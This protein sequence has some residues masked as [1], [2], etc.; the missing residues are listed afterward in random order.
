MQPSI[1]EFRMGGTG[2][3]GLALS[4]DTQGFPAPW[5][6]IMF[7]ANPITRQVQAIKIYRERGGY[8]LEL[9]P[10]FMTTSDEW[11]RPVSIHFGPDACLYVVDWYNKIISHNEVPRNH[12]D[13]DKTRGRVWRIRP[14]GLPIRTIPN[15]AK[16][17]NSDLLKHLVS[18]NKW[19][20][21][22]ALHQIAQRSARE[23]AGKLAAIA[24]SGHSTVPTQAEPE[25]L[26]IRALWAL[27]SVRGVEKSLLSQLIQNL[28]PFVRREAVRVSGTQLPR[29]EAVALVA[30][31][32]EDQNH[33]VRSE[34]IRVA[35]GQDAPWKHLIISGAE[36]R[37]DP[38]LSGRALE[39][40]VAMAKPPLPNPTKA[41]PGYDRE[42]ER[43][44]IRA[45]LE[46]HPEEL[47]RFLDSPAAEKLPG[48]NMQFAS[49]AL[50]PS[51]AA[52]RLAKAFHQTPRIPSDEELAILLQNPA[53]PGVSDA[54]VDL[55]GREAFANAIAKASTRI[56]TRLN[57]DQVEPLLRPAAAILL[58]AK[59]GEDLAE[60][61]KLASGYKMCAL[62]PQVT[63]IITDSNT[64]LDTALLALRV[65]RNCQAGS[66]DLLF[67]LSTDDSLPGP[68]RSEAMTTLAA[69][70]EPD[71]QTKLFA[72][73]PRL[74]ESQR[75]PLV[76]QLSGNKAGA[77]KLLAAVGTGNVTVEELPVSAL[78]KMH[79]ILGGNS[80]MDELWKKMAARMRRV[81]RFH[82]T[83]AD[84]IDTKVQL[85]GPFTV[86][87]WVR[88]DPDISNVDGIL[89]SGRR[90]PD[91]L[92]M[93]F[94]ASQFRVWVGGGQNDIVTAKRKATPETWTHYAV[95][96]DQKGEFRVY[97]NGELDAV[98]KERSAATYKELDIARTLPQTS[99]TSAAMTEYRI[100]N[101]A[102]T[103]SEILANFDHCFAGEELPAGLSLYFPGNSTEVVK[104]SARLI[105]AN[106]I[107]GQARIENTLEAPSLLTGAEA[108]ALDEKFAKFRVLAEAPGDLASGR[109]LFTTTCLVC[110]QAGGQ[111]AGFA[112]N[113][114]GS[115]LRG[116][117]GLLRAIITPSAA[118]EAGYR[119]FRV[120]TSDGDIFEGF[121]A[122]QDAN[123]IILRQPN[124]EPLKIPSVNIKRAGYQ[125]VSIMPDGLLEGLQPRQVSDLFAFLRTLK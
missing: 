40:L 23:L 90:G 105:A 117:D 54:V 58:N 27:E 56:R 124:A 79:T 5:R 25:A 44:L 81:L 38:P 65:L 53:L 24:E 8:R 115:S 20:W 29:E 71:A 123:G 68:L 107:H 16:A 76:E 75:R 7:V 121:L 64:R 1:A 104:G 110:H 100:W 111:G 33:Y 34:V 48:E 101:V 108:H 39:L 59:N 99:G 11:F 32:A 42:F 50:P 103:P 36:K 88:L 102:R 112:P 83:K 62:E 78:E 19:E 63:K 94:F 52:R 17:S 87:A 95:T 2:L 57:S 125:N 84:Y 30:P 85:A 91:A 61:L 37:P 93:N 86:E 96:R 114:D 97:I 113:L 92:D 122:Q 116:T 15:I 6:D 118:M 77:V 98:S 89:G 22:A 10:D 12:P 51:D 45:A 73:W 13:R 74:P 47:A 106:Q 120:Q 28:N 18:G 55:C 82:G 119:K 4:E 41:G 21:N 35:G 49:L 26:Q 9:L 66:A 60:G 31:L 109:Q 69:S 14:E 70:R 67:K 72:L 3:S 43:S 46:R 80:D